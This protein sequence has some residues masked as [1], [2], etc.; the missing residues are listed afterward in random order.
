MKNE[1]SFDDINDMISKMEQSF[2]LDMGAGEI[3]S[4]VNKVDSFGGIAEEHGITSEQVYVIKAN[5]R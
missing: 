4:I 3:I 5:F 1:N 2:G